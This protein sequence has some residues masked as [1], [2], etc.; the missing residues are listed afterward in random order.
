MEDN[1]LASVWGFIWGLLLVFL[2]FVLLLVF[3]VWGFFLFGVFLGW[4]WCFVFVVVLGGFL[5]GWYFFL[6]YVVNVYKGEVSL[7][8]LRK[9]KK[10]QWRETLHMRVSN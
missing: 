2:V 6:C 3:W 9:Y 8:D 5:G 10:I 7:T 4:F 1:T